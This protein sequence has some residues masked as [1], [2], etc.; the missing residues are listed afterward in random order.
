MIQMI[1]TRILNAPQF[2]PIPPIVRHSL[3]SVQNCSAHSNSPFLPKAPSILATNILKSYFET[4]L[5][6]EA[7][8]LF[9][10]MPDKDVVSWTAMITGYV[11]CNHHNHA[12]RIFYEMT[13]EGMPPNAFTLSSALKACK[14]MK[15]LLRGALVHGL[16]LK[17]GISGCIYVDNALMDMYATCCITMENAC[18]V[19]QHIHLKNA[20]TWTTLISGHTHRGHGYAALRLFRLMMSK[21]AELDPFT[22]S[23]VIRACASIGSHIYGMQLH[24]AV[25]KHSFE[26][27]LPVMNS[28]LDMYFKCSTLSEANQYFHEM[29]E[30]DLITWNTAIAGHERSDSSGS[31]ELFSQMQSQGFCPN[32]FTFTSITA[33]CGNLAILNRGKEVHGGIVRRS[34]DWNL[35]LNNAL[36]DMYAKCGKIDDSS[37][38]FRN[39]THRD[40]FSWTSMMIGYGSHGYGKEAVQLFDDMVKVGVIPDRIVFVA[41]ISACSHAGLLDEGLRYFKSMLDDYKVTPNQEIYGCVVDLLGRAG[42]VEEA[43]KLI[44]T[45][46]FKADES[47]WGALLGACKAHGLPKLGTLAALKVMDLS[48]NVTGTYVMVSNIYA[49]DGKWS[50]SAKMRK[51]LRG[52]GSKKEAGRS[53][54]EV[55]NRVYSFIVGD[56][57]GSHIVLV[58]GILDMLIWDMKVGFVPALD[59]L[60]H[61]LEDL[62]KQ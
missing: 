55:K 49:A 28:M 42:R 15:S 30:K 57:M 24:A 35:A 47:V 46:P 36:I 17:N 22:I 31:L 37:K 38:I 60:T 44:E 25:I 13:R 43:Y 48:P 40:L 61:D 20:V 59:S 6:K 27:N 9:D 1:T 29:T 3:H 51:L 62:K 50:E 10:E 33:A 32:C 16:T 56:K 8:T 21:E 52:I 19:F 26:S 58:Y 2:H 12:W 11:S 5:T 53:W 7:R 14:G 18:M 45:M 54:V 39:M 23:I 41:V 34:L 4:G